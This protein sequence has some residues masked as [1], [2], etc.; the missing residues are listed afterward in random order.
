MKKCIL[1]WV[2]V[3]I[4]SGCASD[5][6]R[7]ECVLGDN[8]E[9]CYL[10]LKT[11]PD[12]DY[13]VEYKSMKGRALLAINGTGEVKKLAEYRLAGDKLQYVSI[14]PM[15]KSTFPMKYRNDLIVN[16]TRKD[17]VFR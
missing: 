10:M 12:F 8:N 3:L 1:F 9:T 6:T 17:F 2:L 16:I 7:V 15:D 5:K 4:F 14:R 13:V 11:S